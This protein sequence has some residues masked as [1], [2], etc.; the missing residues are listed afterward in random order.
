MSGCV[1]AFTDRSGGRI[2]VATEVAGLQRFVEGGV[3][4]AASMGDGM[5]KRGTDVTSLIASIVA[6]LVFMG[7]QFWMMVHSIH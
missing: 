1:S 3:D 4:S 7:F 5:R 6:F 2:S